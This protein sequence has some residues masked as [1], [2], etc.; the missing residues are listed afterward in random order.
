VIRIAGAR[1]NADGQR[2][3]IPA[4]QVGEFASAFQRRVGFDGEADELVIEHRYW[5]EVVPGVGRFAGDVIGQ[6]RCRRYFQV[7]GVA[8]MLIQVGLRED[9]AAPGLIEHV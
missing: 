8:C 1:R 7:V 3:W 5:R 9:A 2:S 6:Q 4:Q